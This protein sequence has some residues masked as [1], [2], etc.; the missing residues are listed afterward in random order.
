[1]GE[2]KITHGLKANLPMVIHMTGFVWHSTHKVPKSSRFSFLQQRGMGPH[3]FP[4]LDVILRLIMTA[5]EK[6]K[7]EGLDFLHFGRGRRK[8]V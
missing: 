1:M 5:A 8:A 7:G 6:R 4:R 2:P 3:L